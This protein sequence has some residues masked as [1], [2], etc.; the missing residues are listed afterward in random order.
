MALIFP[1]LRTIFPKAPE[2]S[3]NGIVLRHI[4]DFISNIVIAMLHK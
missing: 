3:Q 2:K 4:A 1:A